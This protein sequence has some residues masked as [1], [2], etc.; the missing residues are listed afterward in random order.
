MEEI[1]VDLVITYECS[2]IVVVFK[3][4]YLYVVLHPY[5]TSVHLL[6]S[7]KLLECHIFFEACAT[8]YDSFLFDK[9]CQFIIGLLN[10]IKGRTLP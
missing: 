10:D 6:I 9:A 8:S 5:F 2:I 1:V 4:I 7:C 3:I